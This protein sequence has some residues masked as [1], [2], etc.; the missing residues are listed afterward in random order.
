MVGRT[1]PVPTT[2]R[3]QSHPVQ[4][5]SL[6]WRW[7]PPGAV[8][9]AAPTAKKIE[10]EKPKRKVARAG[11]REVHFFANISH[12]F[13]PRSPSSKYFC[14]EMVQ[15]GFQGTTEVLPH[16]AAQRRTP[17]NL[18]QSTTGPQQTGKRKCSRCNWNRG[19]RQIHQ[20]PGS[21]FLK[22]W[23]ARLIQ[24]DIEVGKR[25]DVNAY[26][27]RDK[28]EKIL[29]NLMSNAFKFTGEEVDQPQAKD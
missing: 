8:T 19:R 24:Y 20:C 27:D 21:L 25:L 18:G 5:S 10:L 29:T 13:A 2:Q 28:L 26:L 4:F 9:A 17:A 3:P 6:S 22:A 16:H 14:E 15:R 12:E 1:G 11:P 7:Y 23:Q